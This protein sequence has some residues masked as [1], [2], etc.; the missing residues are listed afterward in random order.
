MN[1]VDPDGMTDFTMN[2]ETGA[3]TQVGGANKEPDRILKTD[4]KG[5]VK[6]KGH[7]LVRKSEQGKPKVAIGGIGK[8]ILTNGM[9]LKTENHIIEVGGKEQPTVTEVESFA[10]KL[11]NYVGKEIKGAY[12][13]KDGSGTTSQMTIGMY[14]DNLPDES[15]YSGSQLGFARNLVLRGFFHTHPC[16]G[17]S[18]LISNSRSDPSTQ[19]KTTRDND[20]RSN[21]SLKF[22]ILTQPDSYGDEYPKKIDYT[23][24]Y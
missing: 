23:T 20:L 12:F 8:G 15:F 13:S 17:N 10:L 1:R 9:N 21:P 24:T 16:Y 7:F 3:V 19:D 4:S 2:Q 14:K 11:S 6:T 18:T 22:F 5:N